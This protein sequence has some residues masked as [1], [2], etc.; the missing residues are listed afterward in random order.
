MGDGKGRDNPGTSMSIGKH[1]RES[2][3]ARCRQTAKARETH[4]RK[5]TDDEKATQ[6]TPTEN[7]RTSSDTRQTTSLGLG[8]G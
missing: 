5:G 4:T 3:D 8:L 2:R 7:I 6:A 1:T